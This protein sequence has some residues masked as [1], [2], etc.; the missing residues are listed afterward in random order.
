M[1]KSKRLGNE[2]RKM[3]KFEAHVTVEPLFNE[4]RKQFE[5]ICGRHGYKA[6]N[7][8]MIK[9]EGAATPS[10]RDT[11]CT[12]YGDAVSDMKFV[13]R[14]FVPELR[15]AG[16]KVW[17]YKIE[18]IIVD[19]KFKDELALMCEH[20]FVKCDHDWHYIWHDAGGWYECRNCSHDRKQYHSDISYGV[21]PEFQTIKDWLQ[22]PLLRP[23]IDMSFVPRRCKHCSV[24]EDKI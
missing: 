14:K 11:F 15:K 9:K 2:K 23:T 18:A 7:L 16:I 13:L 24:R 22:C 5:E 19:S 6:A 17:R 3:Q 20:E 4:R 10:N 12:G 21:D 1:R 8:V